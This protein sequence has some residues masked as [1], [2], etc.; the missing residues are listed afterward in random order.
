MAGCGANCAIKSIIFIKQTIKYITHEFNKN[1][2]TLM[3]L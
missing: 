2:K 3:Q 1:M